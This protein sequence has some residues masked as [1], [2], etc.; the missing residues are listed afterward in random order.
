MA[1]CGMSEIIS[2]PFVSAKDLDRLGLTAEHPYRGL[3][4]LANPLADDQSFLQP[5][6]APNLIKAVVGNRRHGRRGSRLFETA[7]AFRSHTA[8]PIKDSY[9]SLGLHAQQGRHIS[10]RGRDDARPIERTILGGILDQPY[11]A[12]TWHG[13]EVSSTF[14]YGKAIIVEFCAA[15]GISDVTFKPVTAQALSWLVPSQSAAIHING[16]F[17]GYCGELHPQTCLG[18]EIELEDAP[19]I[20]ELDL[21]SAFNAFAQAKTFR[22]E[23]IRFPA[24]TRD[25]ALVVARNTTHESMTAA[26]AK[27]PKKKH[28]HTSRLFDVYFGDN[29]PADKKSMAYSLAFRSP[30]RTLK[31]E[32]VDQ[33]ITSLVAWLKDS[34]G[35]EQR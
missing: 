26:I 14:H 30:E 31:D 11:S 21:E 16:A 15:F 29:L 25:L 17:A 32:E 34:L 8:T 23:A 12:K 2:F 4:A 9:L 1:Q 7:R 3:V 10:G 22:T 19:V 35:A 6:L 5:N 13:G 20:F 27:F 33:E 28:L 18:Y 24:V